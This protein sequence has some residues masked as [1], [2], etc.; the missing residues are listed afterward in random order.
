MIINELRF[1]VFLMKTMV[2]R[3]GEDT[4][5][6]FFQGT[7]RLS[8]PTFFGW[9]FGFNGK[10]QILVESMRTDHKPIMQESE[11]VFEFV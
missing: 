3:F 5:Y 9:V 6:D 8:R 2:D 4:E 10:V 1:T 7:D 11:Y